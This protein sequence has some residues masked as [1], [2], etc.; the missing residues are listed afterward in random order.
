MQKETH[1]GIGIEAIAFI[2]NEIMQ[3]TEISDVVRIAF[4]IIGFLVGSC[5]IYKGIKTTGNEVD[6]LTNLLKPITGRLEF[7]HIDAL[8]DIEK[9]MDTIHGHSDIKGLES[10]FRMGTKISSLM[11]SNCTICNKPR[12]KRGN[13]YYDD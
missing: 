7:A 10:D 4:I 9:H 2:G 5:F 11:K 6:R 1:I 3:I 12:N 8:N 13:N